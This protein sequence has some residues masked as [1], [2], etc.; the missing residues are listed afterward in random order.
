MD[1]NRIIKYSPD[2]LSKKTEETY[3]KALEALKLLN[4]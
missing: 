4:I 1:T 2:L 3:N